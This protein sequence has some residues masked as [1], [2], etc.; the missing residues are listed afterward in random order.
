MKRK[1]KYVWMF[2]YSI[3]HFSQ[4]PRQRFNSVSG[5]GIIGAQNQ[6]RRNVT[7]ILDMPNTTST[8]GS[9]PVS[10]QFLSAS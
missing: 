9:R 8:S 2:I 10:L 3:S 5:S 1:F 4:T 6:P 7:T